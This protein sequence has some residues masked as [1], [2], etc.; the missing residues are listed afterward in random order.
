VSLA[1]ELPQRAS[2]PVL[3]VETVLARLPAEIRAQ[4]M[5]AKKPIADALERLCVESLDDQL[6]DVAA[7]EAWLPVWRITREL[8]NAMAERRDE[9]AAVLMKDLEGVERRLLEHLEDED[10]GDSLAWV[11]GFLRAY[12]DVTLS[13]L[14]QV[15]PS[16]AEIPVEDIARQ[17]EVRFLMRGNVALMAASELSRRGLD[18]ARA[19]EL[20][21]IAFELTRF[22]HEL[23]RVGLRVAPFP[24]QTV[25]QRR[26]RQAH[27]AKRLRQILGPEDEAILADARLGDLR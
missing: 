3:D 16:V 12:A 24:F 14:P 9:L 2:L 5:W 11:L 22:K 17:R 8:V 19:G 15:W 1:A 27:Y 25:E 23:E 7:D 26:G 18:R 10:A 6:L 13:L 21:D 4:L 20:V